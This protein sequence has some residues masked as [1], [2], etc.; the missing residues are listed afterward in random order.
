MERLPLPDDWADAVNGF[1]EYKRAAGCSEE[2]LK[3][4][5]YQ[6]RRFA[7]SCGVGPESADMGH[8]TAALAACR[9]QSTRKNLRN[10]LVTFFRWCRMAGVRYDDPTGAL[11]NMR[12]PQPHPKPCP[13]GFI[14]DAFQHANDGERLMLSLAAEYG[15][16]R[17]EIAKVHSDDVI[18]SGAGHSLI[19][20]GKGDKQR[21]IPI[22]ADTAE[23]LQA[24][25]G[26]VFPGRWGG[27]VEESYVSR[28]V[29]ALL[30]DGYSAH[31][32]RHRFATVA[33]AASH[34]MLGVSRA[35]GHS[36]TEVTE[37]YV[38]LPD[39]SLCGL[40][41]AAAMDVG[42]DVSRPLGR[43]DGERP[44]RRRGGKVK[45]RYESARG[46]TAD[47]TP[48]TTRML[49]ML[50]LDLAERRAQ[51]STDF[52]IVA[53]QFA[54]YHR[55][56]PEGHVRRSSVVRA[57]AR[58]L[59]RFGVVKLTPD[60]HGH[61]RGEIALDTAILISLATMMAAEWHAKIER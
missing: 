14:D 53:E 22:R 8:V 42:K 48:E 56:D 24:A 21:I 7:V 40:V 29:S 44:A 12:Q 33:Y 26:Y 59:E 5:R 18:T 61:I 23:R 9:S 16:R 51:G 17:G 41:N 39:D 50:T 25:H 55:A 4:R 37:H 43:D 11:P 6:L 3:T 60:H 45:Y 35:L 28:H 30:P 1:I 57:A 49:L 15:L 27:H 19:V 10:C 47:T 38:A 36:T 34:D 31:K 58:R 32:L 52:D 13:D 20:R 54:S 46:A 2:T